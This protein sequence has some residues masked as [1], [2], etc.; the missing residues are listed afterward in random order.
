MAGKPDQSCAADGEGITAADAA[1]GHEHR[2]RLAD[3]L[4]DHIRALQ[5]AVFVKPYHGSYA[6]ARFRPDDLTVPENHA[7]RLPIPEQLKGGCNCLL[8]H[9]SSLAK[10]AIA[11]E[12]LICCGQTASQL[13]QATQ[14]LGRLSS[15]RAST[16]MG[17][18]KP[19]P[20]KV[21]SL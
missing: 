13:R 16:A 17:A 10:A 3:D 19:P 18:R 12:I 4:V 7:G 9:C 8:H 5:R 14:A 1:E 6:P 20:E 21:C 11:S 15:G 2:R